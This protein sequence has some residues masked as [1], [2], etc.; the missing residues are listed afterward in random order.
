MCARTYNI[1]ELGN[2]Q[3]LVWQE[4]YWKIG[5]SRK[6]VYLGH[7]HSCYANLKD[8]LIQICFIDFHFI[9]LAICHVCEPK[10]VQKGFGFHFV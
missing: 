7:G 10:N 2:E 9:V 1:R 6:L 8:F 5:T 4:V 3:G